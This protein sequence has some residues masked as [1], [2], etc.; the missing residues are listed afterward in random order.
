MYTFIHNYTTTHVHVHILHYTFRRS[1]ACR[2]GAL[3]PPCS[4]R[5]DVLHT[6]I[7]MYPYMYIYIYIY[8]YVFS[9]PPGKSRAKV[10]FG[11]D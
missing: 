5:S 11:I 10:R 6:Y 3:A 7:H 1:L 2:S 8:I 9:F 4:R